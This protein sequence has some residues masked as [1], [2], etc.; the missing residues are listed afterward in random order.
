MPPPPK[1]AAIKPGEI[2]RSEQKAKEAEAKAKEAFAKAQ[3]PAIPLKF[4][5]YASKVSGASREAFFLDG[6]EIEIKRENDVIHGRYKVIRIGINSAVVEDLNDHDQ[7]TL[8]LVA[9]LKS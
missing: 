6:D 3:H 4:Y 5:G 9:E 8:P 1:V 7:Q 2:A